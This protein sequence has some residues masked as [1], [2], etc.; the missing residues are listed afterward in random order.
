[1]HSV[2]EDDVLYHTMLPDFDATLSAEES[3]RLLSLLTAAYVRVPLVIAF[4]A[5]DRMRALIHPQLQQVTR[6]YSY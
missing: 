1:M 2:T 5:A 6:Y 4:F 3:Q